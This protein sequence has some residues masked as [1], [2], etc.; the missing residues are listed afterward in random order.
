MSLPQGDFSAISQAKKN[1]DF[2]TLEALF[3]LSLLILTKPV[4]WREFFFKVRLSSLQKKRCYLW[5]TKRP[6]NLS[7]YE[8]EWV[9]NKVWDFH[10]L[11][12]RAKGFRDYYYLLWVFLYYCFFYCPLLL[13][14]VNFNGKANSD[15]MF[16][17]WVSLPTNIL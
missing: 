10:L 7:S 2:S 15:L 17:G 8:K 6:W 5:W 4:H 11:V 12:W 9:E 1:S 14:W 3:F 13:W 16:S